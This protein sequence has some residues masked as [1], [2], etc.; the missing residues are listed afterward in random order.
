MKVKFL[1]IGHCTH[2]ERMVRKKGAYKDKRFP[3]IIALIQHPEIGNILFD[4]GYTEHFAHCT[5]TYPNKLYAD[6]TPHVIEDNLLVNSLL[7]E[8]LTP[9]DI[10]KVIISHFHADH[11]SGLRLFKNAKF[12][13]S[14]RGINDF[15]KH[16]GLSGL[17]KGYI[18]DLL[19]S[20]FLKRVQYS[21]SFDFKTLEGEMQP[22]FFGHQLASDDSLLIVDLPGHAA[23]QIGLV[24]KTDTQRFFMVADACWLEETYKNLEYPNLLANIVFHDSFA[25]KWT[26]KKIH[27]LH[28]RHKDIIIIPSHCEKTF[29]RIKDAS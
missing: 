12:I 4:T 10:D 16:K 14:K 9:A 6:V 26:I 18:H 15:N 7:E 8:G 23:G 22:F 13:C 19:P 27:D 5:S 25:Y 2:C 24:I 29:E 17:R 11:I 20:D 1:E 3:M 21:E 28:N